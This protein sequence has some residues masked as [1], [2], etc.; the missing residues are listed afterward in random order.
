MTIRFVLALLMGG[1][2]GSTLAVAEGSRASAERNPEKHKVGAFLGAR[3]TEYPDWF[4]DSFLDFQED[5]REAAENEKRVLLLFHQDNCPYCNALIEK[6]LAQKDIESLLR[7]KFDVIALNMWGDREVVPVGGET[8]TEK[9]FAKALKVQF[10]PTLIF[11]NEKAR[12]V[13]RLNGYLPPARF[14]AALDYVAGKKETETTFREYL[15]G[16]NAGTGKTALNKEAFFAPPPHDL[17]AVKGKP[18]AVFFEQSDCP[19]C[20]E[21][22][23]KVLGNDETRR[24]L[25]PFYSIQLDMWSDTPLVT[26][27]GKKTTAREWAR[28]LRVFYAPTVVLFGEDGEEVIRAEAMLKRFHTQSMFDYVASEAYREQPEFQRYLSD[29]ADAIREKGVDVNIWD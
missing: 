5:I 26:P 24:L 12:T 20:D 11:L 15:A 4:K 8:L 23:R 3:E 19:Q 9:Q 21:F 29:R 7:R 18:V 25:Q 6:N 14:K 1:M 28:T 17:A 13:L 2:L 16:L 22:H 27:T 10:T